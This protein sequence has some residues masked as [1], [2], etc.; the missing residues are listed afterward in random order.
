MKPDR[1]TMRSSEDRWVAALRQSHTGLWRSLALVSFAALCTSVSGCSTIPAA[2]QGRTPTGELE[3]SLD[4]RQLEIRAR[5]IHAVLDRLDVDYA[6]P[7]VPNDFEVVLSF[8]HVSDVQIR[9]YGFVSQGVTASRLV[10]FAVPGTERHQGIDT[11]EEYPFL[12]QVQAINKVVKQ[13]SE[14]PSNESPSDKSI[15]ASRSRPAPAFMIHTGDSTEVATQGELLSFLSV[16]NLLEIPWFNVAGNHDFL[17]FG[18]FKQGFDFKDSSGTIAL[19]TDRRA[20]IEFHGDESRVQS[21]PLLYRRHIQTQE[22]VKNAHAETGKEETKERRDKGDKDRLCRDQPREM[23]VPPSKLHGFDCDA[24]ETD[25]Q[26][27][28]CRSTPKTNYS[29][30]T[31]TDPPIRIVVL[32]TNAFDARVPRRRRAQRIGTGSTGTVEEDQF[33]WLRQQLID[34]SRRGEPVLVMGHHPLSKL[35]GNR[36]SIRKLLTSENP[37]SPRLSY[38]LDELRKEKVLAYFGGHKHSGYLILHKGTAEK[39][40]K[41]A[42]QGCSAGCF[43]EVIA[44]SLHEFPQ[45]ALLVRVL[46]RTTKSGQ[47]W[48]DVSPIIPKINRN[49]SE[50]SV[51]FDIY[52]ETCE[53]A[54][55]N[56]PWFRRRR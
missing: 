53:K 38:L 1:R 43:L 3:Y 8:V 22:G 52:R 34:A 48:V 19:I 2:V 49:S 45:I 6:L 14:A 4:S 26:D 17:L 21:F 10:D 20:F 31:S 18:N 5:E 42:L 24:S 46:K 39:G 41:E 23:T 27:S 16:A 35:T 37:D 54:I 12:A 55:E 47:L 32:D 11:R 28:R 30:T 44:P 51:D 36:K 15:P 40:D 13:S 25:L 50:N 56:K 7:P 33:S 29:F 9:D